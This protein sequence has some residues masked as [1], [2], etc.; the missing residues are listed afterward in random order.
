MSHVQ[1][2]ILVTIIVNC[3]IAVVVS[4]VSAQFVALNFPHDAFVANGFETSNPG[5]GSGAII[6]TQGNAPQPA[7]IQVRC[8]GLGNRVGPNTTCTNYQSG[9]V[10]PDTTCG[11]NEPPRLIAV[12]RSRT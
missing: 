8:T 3:H 6:D 4:K 1:L 9:Q 7:P 2:T 10:A 12:E 11:G 5:N